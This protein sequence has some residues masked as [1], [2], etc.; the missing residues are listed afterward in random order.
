M[1]TGTTGGNISAVTVYCGSGPVDDPAFVQSGHD[2]GEILA[3]E[4][5]RGIFGGGSIGVMGAFGSSI[6]AHGGHLTAVIP[7]LLVDREQPIGANEDSRARPKNYD[8]IVAKDMAERKKR[9][10]DGDGFVVLAGGAGTRDELWEELTGIQ[11]G[12]HAKPIVV[13]NTL[14][15]FKY[16]LLAIEEMRRRKF[17][18]TGLEFESLFAV[19]GHVGE[20]LPNL[21]RMVGETNVIAMHETKA[22]G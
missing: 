21:R 10:R 15:V 7:Q 3:H 1:T 20:A 6:L 22:A 13:V 9:F 17:I 19:V 11:I 14:N 16:V 4:K 18:R 8:L 5:V 12:D 2:L